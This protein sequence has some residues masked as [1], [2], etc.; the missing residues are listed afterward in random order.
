LSNFKFFSDWQD[1]FPEAKMGEGA[2]AG[3]G[4]IFAAVM[5][6]PAS[7]NGGFFVGW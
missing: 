4:E 2:R 3:G 7:R 5:K 6:S 1:S